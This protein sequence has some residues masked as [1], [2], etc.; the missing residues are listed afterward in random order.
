MLHIKESKF[1]VL[2]AFCKRLFPDIIIG[3]VKSALADTYLIQKLEF[4]FSIV[5]TF[6]GVF[7]YVVQIILKLQSTNYPLLCVPV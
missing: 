4:N 1:S 2:C 3:F 7:V 6:V 5:R